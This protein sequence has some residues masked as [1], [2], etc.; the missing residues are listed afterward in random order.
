[1][2]KKEIQTELEQTTTSI[3][4]RAFE[5]SIA[6]SFIFAVGENEDDAASKLVTEIRA[7]LKHGST[8][9]FVLKEVARVDRRRKREKEE[10]EDEENYEPIGFADLIAPK[11][12]R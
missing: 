11:N 7:N 3:I 10:Q 4:A 12:L 6:K 1:M 8:Y 5:I 2:T 9:P